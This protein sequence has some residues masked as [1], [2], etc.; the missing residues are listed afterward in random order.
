MF[1][2]ITCFPNRGFL[3]FILYWVVLVLIFVYFWRI[4]SYKKINNKNYILVGLH[5]AERKR[6]R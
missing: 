1:Y 3:R 6:Q 2:C 4:H 5:L